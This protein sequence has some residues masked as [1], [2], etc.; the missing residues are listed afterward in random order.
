V[1]V[2]PKALD[3]AQRAI[4]INEALAEPHASRAYA[5]SRSQWQWKEAEDEYQRSIEL[6]DSYPT[7]HQWYAEHLTAMGRFDEARV[8]I[9]KAQVL[10]PQ[11]PIV[12]TAVGTVAYFARNVDEAIEQ[13]LQTIKKHPRFARVRLRLAR[14]Y[15]QKGMFTHAIRECRQ[16]LRNSSAR[17]TEMVQ[18][19]QV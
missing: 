1:G 6:D 7:S 14:A 13:Y 19:G 17:Q 15:A 4:E 9:Q 10:D 12:S 11:S 18:L 16:G 8:K 5:I 3:F 2:F